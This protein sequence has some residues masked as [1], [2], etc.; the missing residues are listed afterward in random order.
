M[1]LDTRRQTIKELFLLITVIKCSLGR[2]WGR[3]A[4]NRIID[5]CT[6]AV[7][8]HINI[9]QLRILHDLY[10][11]LKMGPSCPSVASTSLMRWS[12]LEDSVG[13]DVPGC[14]L[15]GLTLV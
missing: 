3:W 11:H 1:V 10:P 15:A 7:T 2:E 9:C 13:V 12:C 5:H 14:G 4:L 6:A 8:L